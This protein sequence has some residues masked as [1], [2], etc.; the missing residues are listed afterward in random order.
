MTQIQK[1]PQKLGS[2]S[3]RPLL[4]FLVFYALVFFALSVRKFNVMNSNTGDMATIVNSFWNTL[5]GRFFYCIYIGMSHFGVHVT[6]AILV[7]LPFY[8]IVPSPYTLL[9]LQSLVI[10]SAGFPFFLLARKVLENERAAWLMTIGFLFYPTIVTNHVNQIHWEYWALPYVVAAV[11]FY[12]EHRF[13]PFA[14]F[15]V[16]AMTGQ[17]S[18]PLT[19][20]AFGIYGAI[21]RRPAKWILTPILMALVYGVLVFKVAIPHFAGDR[22]YVVAHY[23][24]DLGNTPG[25]FIKTCLTQPWRPL[26]QV[27]N[28]DRAIYLLQLLQPLLWILPLCAPEFVLVLPSLGINLIV[29]EPGFRVIAWHYNPT[30]GAL[31]CVATLFGIRQLV[32]R[33]DGRWGWLPGTFGLAFAVCALCISSWMLWFNLNDYQARP[34][35]DALRKAESLV[36]PHKSILS[37][38]TMMARFADRPIVLPLMQFDP[39][40]VMSDLWSREKLYTLDYIILDGNERRFSMEVITRDIVMSFY[41]NSNYVLIFNEDN[42]FVFRRRESVLLTP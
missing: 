41:T 26:G 28:L 10:A 12:N 33:C 19:V 5:H 32:K 27:W 38:I 23:F 16:L 17:E 13:G 24:G 35:G 1:Q 37:P 9:L 21:C 14:L 20:A 11:Y 8:A 25:E 30:V 7:A 3:V 15:A 39:R 34:D 22:G 4:I 2:R 31:L 18:S 36:P 40:H 6:P 42:V 29:N